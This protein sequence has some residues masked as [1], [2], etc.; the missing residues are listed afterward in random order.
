[1]SVGLEKRQKLEGHKNIKNNTSLWL[2][3]EKML[4]N[5]QPTRNYISKSNC[6]H[7]D[8]TKIESIHKCPVL[9]Q[10]KETCSKTQKKN[11][12]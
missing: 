3:I 4:I 5:I 1:M 6:C 8:E 2:G 11:K 9:P 7:C 10:R 12:K